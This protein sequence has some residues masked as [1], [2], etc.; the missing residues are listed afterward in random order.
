MKKRYSYTGSV[1]LSEEDLKTNLTKEEVWKKL[2]ELRKKRE[3]ETDQF[4]ID[5]LK[6]A[7]E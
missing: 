5:F 6:K 7:L 4:I 3:K 2:L 1:V